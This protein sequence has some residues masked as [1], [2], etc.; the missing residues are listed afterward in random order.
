V[1][2]A[3]IVPINVSLTSIRGLEVSIG[4]SIVTIIVSK[5][6]KGKDSLLAYYYYIIY[7]S[8]IYIVSLSNN[9][10]KKSF[11]KKGILVYRS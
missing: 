10:F 5:F 3:S 8:T 9:L 6:S 1:L 11:R 2:A 4:G 7:V